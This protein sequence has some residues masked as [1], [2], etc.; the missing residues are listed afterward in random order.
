M[1]EYLFSKYIASIYRESKQQFNQQ[2]TDFDL[3]ATQSDVL[4]FIHEH[5][6]LKQKDISR[7]MSMDASL[8]ARDLRFLE[9]KN[10]VRRTKDK[11]DTR[12][13]IVCLTPKGEQ[14]ALKIKSVML[15]WWQHFFNQ[16]PEIDSQGF[17]TQL[18]TI[19]EALIQNKE[20]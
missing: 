3:R 20:K 14:T 8:L 10:V 18:L 12:A 6:N 7:E 9:E 5:P 11:L 13:K 17:Q 19:Y 2:F 1:K 4:L 16:H 15:T